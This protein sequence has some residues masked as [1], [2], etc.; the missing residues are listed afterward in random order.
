[1]FHTND[2]VRQK[3]FSSI[4]ATVTHYDEANGM[5]YVVFDNDGDRISCVFVHHF[6]HISE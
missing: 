1:M 5:L 3:F 4:D 6:I 2:R